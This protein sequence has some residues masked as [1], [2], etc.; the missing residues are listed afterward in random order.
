MKNFYELACLPASKEGKFTWSTKLP[1]FNWNLLARKKNWLLT[2]VFLIYLRIDWNWNEKKILWIKNR[3]K[4]SIHLWKNNSHFEKC[5]SSLQF[6]EKILIP[7][8]WN[9][10]KWEYYLKIKTYVLL[11]VKI[12]YFWEGFF[13]TTF[14]VY[15]ILGHPIKM[16]PSKT[17]HPSSFTVFKP[18]QADPSGHQN[19]WRRHRCRARGRNNPCAATPK[20]TA[21]QRSRVSRTPARVGRVE[22]TKKQYTASSIAV[23]AEWKPSSL[24]RGPF[25]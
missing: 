7:R 11:S 21:P 22:T 24:F 17:F 10:W 19:V 12:V 25:E 1:I 18:E 8:N 14:F 15:W 16:N 23:S 9:F 2:E 4:A 3:F 20:G 5:C 13:S 6:H